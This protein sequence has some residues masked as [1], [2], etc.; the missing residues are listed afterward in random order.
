MNNFMNNPLTDMFKKA[1]ENSGSQSLDM[2]N[3]I[4]ISR[5]FN[6]SSWIEMS[7]KMFENM[8]WFSFIKN[9]SNGENAF[10]FSKNFKNLEIFSDLSHL[11]LENSQ[12]MMRRQAEIF[13]KHSNEYNKFLQ[14]IST[15]PQNNIEIQAEFVKNSFES[16]ISDFKE[17]SEMYS[18]SN[19]ENFEA[20]SNKFV[21]ALGKKQNC[22]VTPFCAD[23]T[24]EKPTANKHKK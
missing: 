21:E 5:Y 18:K 3:N 2:F 19:F 24:K 23:P 4:D 8:P 16:L 22:K 6:P 10:D 12:A 11:S 15:N 1:F 7:N 20:A 9:E 17:L 14:N 13:Q